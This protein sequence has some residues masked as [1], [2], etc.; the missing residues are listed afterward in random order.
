M[1]SVKSWNP[2]AY[3]NMNNACNKSNTTDDNNF[4]N[5]V[6][7]QDVNNQDEK[8]ISLTMLDRLKRVIID[9]T[10]EPRKD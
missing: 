9:D 6:G 3:D 8:V 4:I 1:T 2:T 7:A 10:S 5:K